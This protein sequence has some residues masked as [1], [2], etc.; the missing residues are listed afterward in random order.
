MR[1]LKT[2]VDTKDRTM[3]IGFIDHVNIRCEDLDESRRFYVEVI[4]LSDGDRTPMSTP[5]ARLY[6]GGHPL[7]HL[8][9]RKAMEPLPR[10]SQM[11]L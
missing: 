7:V 6:S 1:K 2:G 11:T 10:I 5:G 8:V 4:G 9:D 3:P